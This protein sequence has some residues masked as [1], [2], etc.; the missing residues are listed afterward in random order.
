MRLRDYW[1][2]LKGNWALQ[3]LIPETSMDKLANVVANNSIVGVMVF[4]IICGNYVISGQISAYTM[5]PILVL[6][7]TYV[8]RNGSEKSSGGLQR[9]VHFVPDADS[10]DVCA[11]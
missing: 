2:V 10:V 9:D 6:G 4:G 5:I 1:D 11:G 3:V 7:A 8:G